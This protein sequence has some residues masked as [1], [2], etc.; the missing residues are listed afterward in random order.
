MSIPSIQDLYQLKKPTYDA[1]IRT[2]AQQTQPRLASRF[3]V[4]KL[5]TGQ[6]YIDGLGVV[7]MYTDNSIYARPKYQEA[8]MFRR[9]LTVNRVLGSV[10][11]DERQLRQ[12]MENGQLETMIRGELMKAA[13]REWDRIIPTAATA[14]VSYGNAG[15]S[16]ITFANDGGRTV[17]ATGGL[18]IDKLIDINNAFAAKEIGLEQGSKLT[19][20]LTEQEQKQLKGQEKLINSLYPNTFAGQTGITGLTKVENMDV[21]TYGSSPDGYQP[22]LPVAGGVRSCFAF[23][24]DGLIV[25][26]F[27]DIQIQLFDMRAHMHDTWEIRAWF[28]IG[29]VRMFGN[30]VVKVTT[31]AS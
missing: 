19:L 29:A 14:D 4:Q 31:T 12:N 7:S 1:V 21:V 6:H 15:E 24:D 23:A 22:I 9:K 25:G 30:K 27:D 13:N 20:A 2:V 28:E 11:L 3:P 10:L 5:Q 17:D 16:T 8:G 26:V 18:T